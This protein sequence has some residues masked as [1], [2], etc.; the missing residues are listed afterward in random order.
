MENPSPSPSSSFSLSLVLLALRGR[1][2]HKENLL[3]YAGGGEK[4]NLP[5]S[6]SEFSLQAEKCTRSSGGA[7]RGLCLGKVK[8]INTTGETR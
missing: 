2:N 4:L 5:F 3:N 6:W 1:I 7:D 8:R